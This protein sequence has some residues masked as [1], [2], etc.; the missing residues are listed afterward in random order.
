[1]SSVTKVTIRCIVCNSSV[2]LPPYLAKK[3]KTCS[4]KC[5]TYY[6]HT[7]HSK[8]KKTYFCT[9]CN[10]SFDRFPS[11]RRGKEP[12]CSRDCY[13]KWSAKVHLFA[14]A[15]NLAWKNGTSYSFSRWGSRFEFEINPTLK[16][17]IRTRD[18]N[19]CRICS[20][21]ERLHTHHSDFNGKNH[22]LN[23]LVTLCASC[24]R[25]VEQ[26]KLPTKHLIVKELTISPT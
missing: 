17:Q 5:G 12:F 24:H 9:Y 20:K 3:Q 10:N 6:R 22:S 8:V 19:Q 16:K 15:N 21:S 14:G 11:Q 1:M 4:R 18:E 7:L 25:I 2:S 26:G 23:N 13:Q